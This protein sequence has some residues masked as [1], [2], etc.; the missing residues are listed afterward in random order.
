[1]YGGEG[2]SRAG[3]IISVSCSVVLFLCGVLSKRASSEELLAYGVEWNSM[4]SARC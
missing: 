2:W 4:K 1:M 3:P